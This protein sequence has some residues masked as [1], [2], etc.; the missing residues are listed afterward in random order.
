MLGFL[1][2]ANCS[3]QGHGLF[4]TD[5]ANRVSF[6]FPLISQYFI[7]AQKK[8]PDDSRTVSTNTAT[9]DLHTVQYMLITD[10]A[11]LRE[12]EQNICGTHCGVTEYSS[13]PACYAVSTA[14]HR[15]FEIM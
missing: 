10:Y 4:K 8:C 13:L 15:R 2:T 12:Q 9:R 6:L 7:S 14:K 11:N 1:T 5:F 3:I